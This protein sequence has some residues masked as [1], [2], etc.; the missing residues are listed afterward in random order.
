[1]SGAASGSLASR[2]GPLFRWPFSS[3]SSTDRGTP[4]AVLLTLLLTL[5]AGEVSIDE[6]LS[7][8]DSCAHARR[9][10]AAT[11]AGRLGWAH[12]VLPNI[13]QPDVG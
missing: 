10:G 9:R 3:N 7:D 11:L 1:M 12:R 4:A 6:S 5:L 2:V 13:G 8:A